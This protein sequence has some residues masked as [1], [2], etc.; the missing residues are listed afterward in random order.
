MSFEGKGS[1]TDFFCCL[2]VSVFE[3]FQVVFFGTFL[4]ILPMR[5][6]TKKVGQSLTPNF[7]QTYSVSCLNFYNSWLKEVVGLLIG[8]FANRSIDTLYFINIK[9]SKDH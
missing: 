2:M 3:M 5:T 7:R 6:S 9:Y 8:N 1:S 4:M